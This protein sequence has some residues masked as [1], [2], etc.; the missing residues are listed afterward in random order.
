MLH[1]RLLFDD[2][3][4]VDEPLNETEAIITTEHLLLGALSPEFR[5]F[6]LRLNHPLL[7]AFGD[8]PGNQPNSSLGLKQQFHC[9]HISC[10]ACALLTDFCFLKASVHLMDYY[11]VSSSSAVLRVRHI[12]SKTEAAPYSNPVSFDLS[13]HL[14]RVI[15]SLEETQLT[16][17]QPP[18]FVDSRL[19][20]N[21]AHEVRINR[22]QNPARPAGAI[23]STIITLNPMQIRTFIV[24][25]N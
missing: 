19:K 1:R 20:W 8:A 24:S 10:C 2:H 13:H 3:R 14:P 16:G 17:V 11:L 7:P 12:Y 15:S 4:G 25:F 18:S 9:E 5:V 23:G 6:S 22:G 21:A